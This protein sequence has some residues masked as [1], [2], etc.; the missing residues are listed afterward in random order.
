MSW[1]SLEN[2]AYM[3]YFLAAKSVP[4][5]A[6]GASVVFAISPW[7]VTHH[8]LDSRMT[9]WGALRCYCTRALAHGLVRV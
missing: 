9:L 2:M 7:Y 8:T 6:V 1:Q 3:A 5:V 4:V